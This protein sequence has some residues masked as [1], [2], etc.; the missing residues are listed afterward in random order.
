MISVKRELQ[1]F[2]RE[3]LKTWLHSA[4]RLQSRLRPWPTTLEPCLVR[5]LTLLTYPLTADC[6]T[7]L[8]WVSP[9]NR[10]SWK[11]L[12]LLTILKSNYLENSSFQVNRHLMVWFLFSFESCLRM[13]IRQKYKSLIPSLS[14]LQIMHH[15]ATCG[16]GTSIC[17]PP[18]TSSSSVGLAVG[19]PV[20]FVL[21][22]IVVAVILYKYQIW[23]PYETLTM[24]QSMARRSTKTE[25]PV[26]SAEAAPEHYTSLSREQPVEQAPI[27]ENTGYSANRSR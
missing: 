20:F 6:L 10:A 8:C 3:A 5:S 13:I 21:L 2:E 15:N 14:H 12:W 27:Y 23:K 1:R 16:N 22:I 18:A 4:T 24:L 17:S 7:W 9:F 25:D 26:Q 11:V 19:L